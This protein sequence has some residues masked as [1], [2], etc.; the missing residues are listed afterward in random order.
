LLRTLR[1]FERAGRLRITRT[2]RLGFA[3]APRHD[4]TLI[5]WE[6]R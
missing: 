3:P 2:E 4:P 5:V 1:G 6:Q